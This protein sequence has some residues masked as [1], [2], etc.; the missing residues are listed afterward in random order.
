MRTTRPEARSHERRRGRS[1][2]RRTAAT[3]LLSRRCATAAAAD[4]DRADGRARPQRPRDGRSSVGAR[5][6]RQ[7]QP[8][9]AGAQTWPVGN[10]VPALTAPCSELSSQS[11]QAPT[12]GSNT[13]RTGSP[14]VSGGAGAAAV[15]V[16][17][18]VVELVVDA[19]GLPLAVDRSRLL[20][21]LL[22][23]AVDG[24]DTG[25]EAVAQRLDEILGDDGRGPRRSPRR[26]RWS[27]RHRQRARPLRR[28]PRSPGRRRWRRSSGPRDRRPPAGDRRSI[29]PPACR[30]A[31]RARRSARRRAPA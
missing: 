23:V 18:Q 12:A 10:A 9:W 6:T 26:G 1:A 8:G 17:Q 19:L 15:G 3:Y 25:D 29:A 5:A 31:A 13:Q 20:G 7:R 14:S 2:A 28:W 21:Q 30:A 11:E 16:A 22:V 27:A 4:G 24:I